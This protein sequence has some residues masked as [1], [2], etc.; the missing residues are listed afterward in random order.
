MAYEGF[1]WKRIQLEESSMKDSIALISGE[2]LG[3]VSGTLAPNELRISGKTLALTQPW[4]VKGAAGCV[5][6][7]RFPASLHPK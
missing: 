1:S 6:T 4:V 7:A 2:D 3:R 5:P